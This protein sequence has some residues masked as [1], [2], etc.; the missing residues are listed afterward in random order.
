MSSSS[1][2]SLASSS[3]WLDESSSS[4]SSPTAIATTIVAVTVYPDQALVTRCGTVELT[5]AESALLVNNLPPSLN[6]QSLRVS[7]SGSAQIKIL[8]V[9]TEASVSPELEHQLEVLAKQQQQ[10]EERYRHIKDTIASLQLQ[11]D[12]V[13]GLSE[14]AI[15]T[16][17]QGL[18]QQQVDLTQTQSM[19]EFVGDRYRHIAA[20]MAQHEQTKYRIDQQLQSTREQLQILKDTPLPTG[21]V[22]LARIQ[23]QTPGT[24]TLELSYRVTKASWKPQYDARFDHA[25]TSLTLTYLAMVKQETGEDWPAVRLTLSTAK[26]SSSLSPPDLLPWRIEPTSVKLSKPTGKMA[27]K[28]GRGMASKGSTDR[29]NNP[30]SDAYRM[31]GA[32]PGSEIAETVQQLDREASTRERS[33]SRPIVSLPA[34]DGI[35]VPSDNTGHGVTVNQ[36]SLSASLSYMALPQRIEMAYLQV[37]VHY[38]EDATPLLPGPVNLFR[39]GIFVGSTRL[40]YVAPNDQFSFALGVE[41]RI[42]VKRTLSQRDFEILT[43]DTNERHRYAIAFAISVTNQLPHPANLVIAEQFPVSQDAQVQVHIDT[44]EAVAT[45]S[46]SGLCQWQLA[47][48]PEQQAH[49]SYRFTVEHAADVDIVGLEC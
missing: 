34:L 35:S 7:G 5:G 29:G 26:P 30:L 46:E 40:N 23:V 36:Q 21:Y 39:Q 31:L 13:Q 20:E 1:S 27:S 41:E 14:R 24:Y 47:I 22:S 48:A 8:G 32:V 9:D 19:F 45:V 6:P 18:A 44:I 25:Q 37:T 2:T 4:G 42:Q 3:A 12:F 11:R 17:A 33:A 15:D 16:Y 38:P 10:L 28:M 49:L 43:D